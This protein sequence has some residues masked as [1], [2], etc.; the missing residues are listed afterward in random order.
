MAAIESMRAPRTTSQLI[1]ECQEK[2][3]RLSNIN[4]I[5]LMWVQ[6]HSGVG[7]GVMGRKTNWPGEGWQWII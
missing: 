3:D 1:L 2:L 6:G 5:N 7:G 4:F